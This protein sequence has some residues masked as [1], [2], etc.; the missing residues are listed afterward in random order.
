MEVTIRSLPIHYEEVGQGIPL[1]LLH[2]LG[3]DHRH[4]RAD[5]EPLG[6]QPGASFKVVEGS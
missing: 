2:G 4:I 6:N 1:F 3:I 5:M